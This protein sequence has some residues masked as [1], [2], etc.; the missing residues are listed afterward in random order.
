M[1]CL[2]EAMPTCFWYSEGH[3]DG[4]YSIVAVACN[5]VVRLKV[6]ASLASVVHQIEAA[7]WGLYR[8]KGG[9]FVIT[10][11]VS[12]TTWMLSLLNIQP[13]VLELIGSKDGQTTVISGR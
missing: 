12:R 1:D 13:Y 3:D 9:A 2:S 11:T 5:G 7:L 6:Y 4:N 8:A 10:I